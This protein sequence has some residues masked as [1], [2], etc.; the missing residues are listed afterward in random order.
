MAGYPAY[1]VIKGL[2]SASVLWRTASTLMPCIW[3]ISPMAD[4]R[5]RLSLNRGNTYIPAKALRRPGTSADGTGLRVFDAAVTIYREIIRFHISLGWPHSGQMTIF[6]LKDKI[7][8][9]AS[10][11][12][13]RL[14]IS[15][16]LIMTIYCFCLQSVIK[17]LGSF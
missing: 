12:D 10:P 4:L 5:P 17:K 14:S 3:G 13:K 2:R 15:H 8:E 16:F 7:F 6:V 11:S 1:G 9:K